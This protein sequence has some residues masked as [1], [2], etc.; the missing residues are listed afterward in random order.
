[1]DH[2]WRDVREL[3]EPGY[4]DRDSS[5]RQ[6]DH[7][8][9]TGG[10]RQAD[11]E[12][13]EPIPLDHPDLPK[14]PNGVF[15]IWLDRIVE[16]AAEATET[17]RELAALMGLGTVAAAVQKKFIVAVRQGYFEPLSIWANAALD[18]GNRKPAV[19]N[20]MTRPLLQRSHALAMQ[21][22]EEAAEKLS[23]RET[24]KARIAELRKKAARAEIEDYEDI[25]MQISQLEKKL[26]EVPIVPQLWAQDVTPEK[27]GR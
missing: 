25:S 16:A 4:R 1:L 10:Q 14:L 5:G 11:T 19:M 8:N 24:A 21:V 18:S 22:S 3:F 23:Q 7:G 26:P 13:S 2:H 6:N 9:S 20:R 27:L 12:W 15:P 17:P